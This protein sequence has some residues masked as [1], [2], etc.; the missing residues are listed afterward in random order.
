[1]R[2]PGEFLE[3]KALG[4]FLW[5]EWDISRWRKAKGGFTSRQRLLPEPRLRDGTAYVCPGSGEH[6]TVTG[7][8]SMCAQWS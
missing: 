5:G 1:M 7:T 6:S 8:Q 4:Y 2:H 3:E